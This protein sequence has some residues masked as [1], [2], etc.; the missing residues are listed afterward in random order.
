MASASFKTRDSVPPLSAPIVSLMGLSQQSEHVCVV[1]PL[2][3]ECR[4]NKLRALHKQK[5]S[6]LYSF[7]L[8]EVPAAEHVLQYLSYWLWCFH[9]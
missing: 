1:H 7:E 4:S 5:N 8:H 2:V 9:E 6:Y 3:E